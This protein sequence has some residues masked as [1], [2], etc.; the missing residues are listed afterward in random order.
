MA[1]PGVPASEPPHPL[2]SQPSAPS[3]GTHGFLRKLFSRQNGANSQATPVEAPRDQEQDLDPNDPD[4]AGLIRRMSRKVVPGLPRT[5][6]FKRQQSE[7]RDNLA[8]V[9]PTPNE[10]RAVSVDRRSR[11]PRTSSTS[12]SYVN[13]RTSAP[14]FLGSGQDDP[15]HYFPSLPTSPSGDELAE[16][17]LDQMIS[18]DDE[19]TL[20]DECAIQDTFSTAD[21]QSMTTSQYDAMI[22]E[23]LEKRWILNLS[24]HF[25]DRSKREKFFVTYREE[26]HIWRRVTISLD[27]RNAP[28]NSLEMDLVHT[29]YQRDKSAKIYEAI[30]ESLPDIQ[31]YDT[32]TNLKLQTTDGRLHVHVVEDG[33]EIISFPPVAQVQHLACRRIRE[34]DIIFDSHMSGFVYKVNVD[35]QTLIKKEIPS[36]DTVEEFLYEVNAL[37]RLRKSHNVIH[38]HGVVVDDHDEHVKG[39]LISYAEQGALID[40]IFE[41]CKEGDMDIP[42][43]TREKWARQIVQG[44]SDVH[45]SGFV[46]GDFTLSNIV[47]DEQNDAKIIDINRRGCPVGWEPPE[48]TPLLDSNQRISMYIGVK[49]DLYQLGMVLWALATQEDEPE[50]QGRPLILGPEVNIPDWYR[51]MA[52]ICLSDDPR[53]RLQALSLLQ[54]FPPSTTHNEQR[55]LS[56]PPPITVDDGYSLQQYLVEGYRANDQ[57]EIKTVEPPSDWSY[58]SRPYTDASPGYEPYYYTRGRSPPSPI[59]SSYGRYDPPRGMYDIAAW[60]AN[61]DIPSSYSDVGIDDI[62]LDETPLAERNVLFEPDT[63]L[64]HDP[65]ILE[66]PEELPKV[67]TPGTSVTEGLTSKSVTDVPIREPEEPTPGI[68]HSEIRS[69]EKTTPEELIDDGNRVVQEPLAELSHKE[70]TDG[71]ISADMTKL[72]NKSQR[73]IPLGKEDEV[74]GPKTDTVEVVGCH[75]YENYP[76]D[77]SRPIDDEKMQELLEAPPRTEEQVPETHISKPEPELNALQL[78]GTTGPDALA[79]ANTE[80]SSKT[81][82]P[83]STCGPVEDKATQLDRDRSDERDVGVQEDDASARDGVGAESVKPPYSLNGIGAAYLTNNDDM[84]REKATIDED[85]NVVALPVASSPPT[86]TT[87]DAKI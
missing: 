83:P 13:P 66:T 28:M 72:A 74:E 79:E 2:Q 67:N 5:Q 26:D 21:T 8:P 33:N 12:Q 78:R 27:Y 41:H 4:K 87:T 34:R 59:P 15:P 58:V 42:W 10:R 51:Q 16:N 53:M 85:F 65:S 36:P 81:I 52:E 63:T 50:S 14:G 29:H 55:E 86:M 43:R 18:K 69:M 61:R 3:S 47:I 1:Q 75:S 9:E 60:A 57:P 76:V 64:P 7:R 73:E 30:R 25:R 82:T 38:F 77:T 56:P 62:P 45:E 80:T 49:S 54:M 44:L 48:A 11:G 19:L 40:L 20:A 35:G 6:T 46:Q 23:E 39:L 37:N 24:M 70:S 71:V 22:H 31:F 84:M 17:K 68:G 32:V